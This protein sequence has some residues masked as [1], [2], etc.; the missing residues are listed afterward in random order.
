MDD[1][2]ASFRSSQ[3]LK[4]HIEFLYS[5]GSIYLKMNDNLL[6]HGC[7]PLTADGQMEEM[8]FFGQFHRGKSYFDCCE[9][10][11]RQA[12]L[13]GLERIDFTEI[14]GLDNLHAAEGILKEAM[15]HAARSLVEPAGFRYSSFARSAVP[16]R[17]AALL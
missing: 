9:R 14:D 17:P 4:K 10:V 16:S 5:V 12:Y 7:V 3:R 15:D 13:G 11:A 6:F 2:R 8:N 1:L